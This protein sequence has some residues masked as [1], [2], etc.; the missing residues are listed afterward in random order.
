[1]NLKGISQAPR[2]SIRDDEE[3]KDES[4]NELNQRPIALT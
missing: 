2:E 4:S 3:M 1:L